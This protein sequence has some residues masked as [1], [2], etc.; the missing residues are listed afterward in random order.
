M[1]KA[2]EEERMNSKN[3]IGDNTIQQYI[4]YLFLKLS[5]YHHQIAVEA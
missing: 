1:D 3:Q 2:V 4:F 5:L